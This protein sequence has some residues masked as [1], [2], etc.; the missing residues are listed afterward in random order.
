MTTNY[1]AIIIQMVSL[2][3]STPPSFI[4]YFPTSTILYCTTI[5]KNSKETI[6]TKM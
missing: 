5:H 1:T 4:N 2:S 6:V 3:L